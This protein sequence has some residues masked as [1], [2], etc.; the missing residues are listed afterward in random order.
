MQDFVLF[1]ILL[2]KIKT[3]STDSKK[4]RQVPEIYQLKTYDCMYKEMN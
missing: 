4:R 1:I 2:P 3:K